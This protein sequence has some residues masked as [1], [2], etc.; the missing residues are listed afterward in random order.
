VTRRTGS[1]SASRRTVVER[2]RQASEAWFIT[3]PLLFGVLLTHR[4]VAKAGIGTLRTGEGRIEYDPAFVDALPDSMLEEILRVESIRILLKHPYSRRPA[5]GEVAY[6]ASN[7]TLKEHLPRINLPAPTAFEVFGDASFSR[8]YFE[9]YCDRLTHSRVNASA[10]R[11]AASTDSREERALLREHF[12][13]ARGAANTQLWTEDAFVRE[14]IDGVVREARDMN[15]WGTLAGS[16]VDQIVAALKPRLDYQRVLSHFHTSILSSRRELT[17]MKPNRRYGFVY[18]GSRH[19]LASRLLVAVDT[20][21]SVS[22]ADLEKAFSTINRI[23]Q[24]GI[25]TIDVLQFDTEIKAPVARL[26]KRAPSVKIKG[27]GGTSFQPVLA[28]ID[29]YDDYDGLIVMTDGSAP[30][31]Q[32]P[33]NRKTRVLWLFHSERTYR[34]MRSN[35]EHIGRCVFIKPDRGS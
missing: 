18:M 24:Y 5:N 29:E 30:R 32:A 6:L 27:R 26:T 20:S 1:G 4:L 19:R 31:P 25:E 22:A 11:K 34:A 15:R 33:K 17:R 13:T 2:L 21:G 7:I 3:E 8:Q 12:D 10:R 9:F 16:L 14:Q 23:F 28:Y 35:V